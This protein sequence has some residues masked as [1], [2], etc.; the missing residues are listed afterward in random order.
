MYNGIGLATPRGSGTNGYVQRNL[1][2]IRKSKEKVN[3]RTEEEL[4]L[5]DASINKVPNKDILAHQRKR[6]ME[7]KC[8]EMEELM[9]E[10]GYSQEEIDE[11]VA[12]FRFMLSNIEDTRER[13]IPKDD[14]GR[15]IVKESHQMAE[16]NREKNRRVKEAFGISPFFVEG[17]SL[18][19]DRKRKEAAAAAAAL[20]EKNKQ[21]GLVK[22][23]DDDD[24]S[25]PLVG[26]KE[27]AKKKKKC[28]EGSESPVRAKK[29]KS[30]KKHRR[31]R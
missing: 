1:S 8:V 27:K 10:Q 7:L 30:S 24:D 21:Y 23:D 3:Y 13:E 5:L 20:A 6:E 18:D 26:E 16:A 28:R 17:S 12:T 9:K 4:K 31:E 19:P 25:P 14:Q 29:K 22:D 11:K 2:F 15:P